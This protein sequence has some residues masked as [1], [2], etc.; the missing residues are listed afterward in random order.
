[1]AYGVGPES[2]RSSGAMCCVCQL[3]IKETD[4]DDNDLTVALFRIRKP[5][6]ITYLVA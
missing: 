3:D 4:D 2:S 5:A 1:M 6:V